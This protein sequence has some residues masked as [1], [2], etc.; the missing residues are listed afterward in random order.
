MRCGRGALWSLMWIPLI[1]A[2]IAGT[3]MA[4]PQAEW[5]FQGAPRDPDGRF[6]NPIRVV[7]K[8]GFSDAAPFLLQRIMG[9]SR[10]LVGLPERVEPDVAAL[11]RASSNPSVTWVGHSTLLVRMGGMNFLTDP[12]WSDGAGPTRFIKAR[13]YVPPGLEIEDLPRI[14]FV[15]VSHNHYDH[16]DLPTLRR[17]AD[18]H[19]EARFLVP[20]ANG[21]LLRKQG[22][23]RVIELDWGERYELGNVT[24]Y[25][26]PSQHWSRR[27]LFD[28][29]KALWSSWAVISPDRRFY[30]GGDTAEFPGFRIIGETL[31]PFDLAALPIGAY[32][33]QVIMRPHHLDPEQAVQAAL[34]L[35]ARRVLG[36]HFGTFDL[37][38]EPLD[39]PPRRFRAA[40]RAADFAHEDA[41][42]LRFGETRPF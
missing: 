9:R 20:L 37:A 21:E 10:T 24:I 25:C 42:V 12:T 13:R 32:E 2:L 41:W 4:E 26:L 34:D 27:G 17:L 35:S 15:V 31:G 23:E 18:D 1:W 22:I 33:P 14:D 19:P 8:A 39:E 30:F 3:A 6:R 7:R 16:L 40:A 38:A 5:P 29:R 28:E 11:H 36:I